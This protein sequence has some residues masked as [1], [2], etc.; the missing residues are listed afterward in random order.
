[1]RV[2]T[3]KGSQAAART[4]LPYPLTNLAIDVIQL[5]PMSI[6]FQLV[7]TALS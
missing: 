5:K 6:P 2:T 7:H 3:G 4:P 1:L